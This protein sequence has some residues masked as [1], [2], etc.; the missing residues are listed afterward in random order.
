[1]YWVVPYQLHIQT[2]QLRSKPGREKASVIIDNYLW[3]DAALKPCKTHAH[4]FL[5]KNCENARLTS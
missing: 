2:S 4:T 3:C 1:M 5:Y